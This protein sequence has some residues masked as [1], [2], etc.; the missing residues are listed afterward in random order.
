MFYALGHLLIIALLNIHFLFIYYREH[1]SLSHLVSFSTSSDHGIKS[2]MSSH[3]ETGFF[4]SSGRMETCL[5][6]GHMCSFLHGAWVL[7]APCL[8]LE[9]IISLYDS[10]SLSLKLEATEEGMGCSTILNQAETSPACSSPRALTPRHY[11]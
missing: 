4:F 5:P 10:A 8:S 11:C 6:P 3:V 1:L 9:F 7:E 2:H